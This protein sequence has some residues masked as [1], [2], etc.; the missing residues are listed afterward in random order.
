MEDLGV[1]VYEK[2]GASVLS[3]QSVISPSEQKMSGKKNQKKNKANRKRRNRNNA[4]RGLLVS[5]FLPYTVR[6]L[7]YTD[8]KML[9]E[10]AAGAGATNV[11]A[12]NGMYDPDFTGIGGQPMWFDQLLSLN[13]PYLKYRVLSVSVTV[14]FANNTNGIIY[15]YVN[16]TASNAIPASLLAAQQKPFGRYGILNPTSSG[17]GQR[18]FRF[19]MPIHT[20]LGITKVHLKNDDYYAGS[21][22]ANPT[23]AA[24]LQVGVYAAP[25]GAIVGQANYTLEM[26][27]H[28]EVYQLSPNATTS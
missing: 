13:G 2:T 17:K 9:T 26:D 16:L 20:V 21:Y 10:T 27:Y 3:M 22:T 23:M 7:K 24:Y 19:R 12:L 8:N 28:A 5:A 6:T 4:G 1:V 14:T 11:Y 18:V 25:G 15:A